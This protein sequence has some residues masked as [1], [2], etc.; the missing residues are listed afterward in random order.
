MNPEQYVQIIVDAGG[1]M[2]LE[3][4]NA[5]VKAAGGNPAYIQRLKSQNYLHTTRAAGES[6]MV[7]AGAKP[8]PPV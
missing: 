1:S 3:V 7:V 8:V 4:W 5:A 2:P 6:S